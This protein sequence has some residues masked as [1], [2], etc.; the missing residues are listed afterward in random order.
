MIQSQIGAL[1]LCVGFGLVT[2]G[3][4]AEAIV[5]EDASG[6]GLDDGNADGDR[7]DG[8]PDL[9]IGADGAT[10]EP[11]VDLDRDGHGNGCEA[12]DDCHDG[13]ESIYD[14]A[15]ELCD[16]L[17]NNCNDAIDEGCPCVDGQIRSCYDGEDPTL[18]IGRCRA[19][20]QICEDEEWSNCQSQILAQEEV[21]DG[22]DNNC[23]GVIDEELTNACGLCGAVP[24][25]VCGDGL[26]NDCDGS[27][28]ESAA[29]CDCDERTRQPCY[30]GPPQTLGV[31]ACRG[32]TFDCIEGEW[33]RCRG[34]VLP[35]DEI[36]DTVDNDCDGFVDEGLANACQQCGVPTPQEVCDTFDNDC[37]GLIDEGLLLV[38]GLCT[39][40]GTEVC[41]DGLD[42]DCDGGTDNGCACTGPAG[43]YPGPPATRLVGACRDGVRSCDP[44]GEFWG[45]CTGYLLPQPEVCDGVDND[46]DGF[47][48]I[49]PRGCDV[50][51][52]GIEECN[53]IDDDCDGF[54]DEFLRNACGACITEILPEE[55]CGADCC[56]GIDDDCDGLVDEG[57]VNACGN[58]G[59]SCETEE[60]SVELENLDEGD[61]DGID[62]EVNE[63]LRLGRSR[64]HSYSYVWVVNSGDSTVTQIDSDSN[65]VVDTYDVGAYP[66]QVA[67]DLDGNAWV[68]NRASD[69]QG[70]VTK[71]QAEGCTGG[72]CVLFHHDIGEVGDIPRA[73]VIDEGNHPW[74]GT[75]NGRTLYQLDSNTGEPIDEFPLSV[76]VYEMAIDS[77]G[78]IWIANLER[79]IEDIGKL[80]AFDSRRGRQIENS[81]WLIPDCSNPYDVSVDADGHVWIANWSCQ[82]VVMFDPVEEEFTAWAPEEEL[83]DEVSSVAVDS[84][85]MIWAATRANDTLA[86]F[87]P[88]EESWDLTESCAGPTDLGISTTG[89]IWAPCWE[90]KAGVFSDGGEPIGEVTVGTFPSGC[91]DIT[92]FLLQSFADRSGVWTV[93]FDCGWDDCSFD[94]VLWEA[95]NE[96]GVT[97]TSLN[98]RTSVDGEAWSELLSFDSSPAWLAEAVDGR[99]VEIAL[100]FTTTD[101]DVSPLV[102]S[103][104]VDW[105]RP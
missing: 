98:V 68:V 96:L 62:E 21:C 11:C 80:A 57:L 44:R 59:T 61:F 43:C 84:A 58:C 63:G 26:D 4:T 42:N 78:I 5:Q 88:V 13:N 14:G 60:W 15:D 18:G 81:P 79:P 46:C 76:R 71:I 37:D 38:C 90:G 10:S 70:T 51:G 31:G 29:G 85:G 53:G 33:G 87:D 45:P 32:G 9:G 86:R 105:Q 3:C 103:V 74:V 8:T 27:I 104:S 28:D 52:R 25:E 23:D 7:A 30:S 47:I 1:L 82:N 2:L 102:T 101:D 75:Y 39:A 16:G 19:G 54:I 69:G 50:C 97:T 67:V 36:C 34:E 20:Y 94:Q 55:T 24:E 91:S 73:I 17:D 92:G 56:N 89:T 49:S 41:G 35:Q 22:L 12:G 72:D 95:T 64:L 83:L 66:S 6:V 77:N 100:T 48:D 99:Y 40:Q 65:V 93:T